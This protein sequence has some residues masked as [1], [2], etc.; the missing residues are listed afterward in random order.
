MENRQLSKG[1]F[2]IAVAAL[3]VS[4]WFA[5]YALCRP[6]NNY[7]DLPTVGHVNSDHNTTAT[8]FRIEDFGLSMELPDGWYGEISVVGPDLGSECE[9]WREDT[10]LGV[11]RLRTWEPYGHNWVTIRAKRISD[12]LNK[13]VKKGI[14]QVRLKEN[15][16]DSYLVAGYEGVR[17]SMTS[18]S[19]EF[20]TVVTDTILFS[21]DGIMYIFQFDGGTDNPPDAMAGLFASWEHVLNSVKVKTK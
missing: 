16:L 1:T 4:V 20:G 19:D 3:A 8:L 15:E 14:C 9:Y 10:V 17:W 11:A 21:A 6:S 18:E 5:V 7:Y 13:E 12:S 2:F